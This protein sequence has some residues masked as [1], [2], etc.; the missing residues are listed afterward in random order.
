MAILGDM[1]ELG[2]HTRAEHRDIGRLLSERTD[3]DV[4]V[5]VGPSMKAAAEVLGARA[6]WVPDMDERHAPGVAGDLRAG[7]VVLLKG[8]RRMRL[9]RLVVALKAHVEAGPRPQATCA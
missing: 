9:E 8:S 1:L 5:L 6:A 4:I 7:D 2:D 3:L